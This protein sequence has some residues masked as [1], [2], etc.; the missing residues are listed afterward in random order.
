M[1]YLGNSSSAAPCPLF[2]APHLIQIA[3]SSAPNLDT[4]GC[5][6][7]SGLTSSHD[8][9]KLLDES[10]LVNLTKQHLELFPWAAL[11]K[12]HLQIKKRIRNL[13][14]EFQAEILAIAVPGSK[15]LGFVY[16]DLPR[17]QP[18]FLCWIT[19]VLQPSF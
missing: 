10:Q 14:T 7:Q 8:F 18:H 2:R 16:R 6:V 9:C 12:W 13:V 3:S 4:I 19:H 1:I 11:R 5:F 17:L 15:I